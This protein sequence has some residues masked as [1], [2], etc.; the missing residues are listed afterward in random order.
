MWYDYYGDRMK[1]TIL[2]SGAYGIALALM[3]N[4]NNCD[5]GKTARI[6]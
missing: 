3:F 6:L 1:V 2:G 5:I 4:K